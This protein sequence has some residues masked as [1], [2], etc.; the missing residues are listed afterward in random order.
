MRSS[1]PTPLKPFR[2]L[3]PVHAPLSPQT[4]TTAEI[5]LMT[6]PLAPETTTFLFT[7]I[8][9]STAQWETSPDM[10]SRLQRHLSILEDTV[11]AFG[12]MVFAW[13]GDGIAAAFSSADSAVH[14]AIAAQGALPE[15]GLRAR[16]G[17]HT[18]EAERVGDDHRGRPV[19]R[20]ARI[21]S[22]GH[23]GQILLSDLSAALIR[24]GPDPVELA[25]LG[26]HR[27]RGL[28]EPERLWQVLHPAL[29]TRFAPVQGAGTTSPDLPVPRT[30]LIGRE[31]ETARLAGLVDTTRIV[32]LTGTGGVGKTRLALHAAEQLSSVADARFVELANLPVGARPDEVART[33]AAAVG[34]GLI[35]DPIA[36]T[37]AMLDGHDAL[38]VI[39]NCEHVIEGAAEVISELTDRCPQLRVIATSREPLGIDGEHVIHVAPLAPSTAWTLFRSRAEA[40]G[41]EPDAIDDE[42][43]LDIVQRL[44]RLPLAIELTAARAATLGLPAIV[45]SLR[46]RSPSSARRRRGKVDRQATM[47]ATIAWSYDLLGPEEQRLLGQLAVFPSGAELDAVLDVAC[48][49]GIAAPE[50][51]DVLASLVD[52]SMLTIEPHGKG[53]RYRMLETMRAFVLDRLDAAGER[54]KAQLA[55]AEWVASI[56]DVP[57]AEASALTTE[58]A[59]IRLERE[60]CNWQEAMRAAATSGRADLAARLCGPPTA[61]FL[62]GRHDLVD[63]VR[64]V[65][66]LC[67]A[68][69]A[70]RRATLCALMVA[71]AGATD[72]AQLQVW[73]DEMIV[74]DDRDRTGLGSLMQWLARI[75]NG[76]FE[77]AVAVCLAGAEDPRHE[78]TTRDL[79]LSMAVLDHF[80][81]TGATTDP[82]GLIERAI[83]SA[84]RS[85][86]AL[87]RVSGRLGA[88][89]GLAATAPDRCIDLVRQAMADLDDVPALTRLT[90]PGSAFRLLGSLDPQVAAAG[91]LE[92]LDAS[93]CRESFVDLIPLSYAGALLEGVGHPAAERV[94]EAVSVTPAAPHL[95]MMDFVE[96]AR[97]MAVRST[98]DDLED[99]EAHVRDALHEIAQVE[100][101]AIASAD[102]RDRGDG[103]VR[104]TGALDPVAAADTR[105][106]ILVGPV[107]TP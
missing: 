40:A 42:L 80:S 75:W 50:A 30:P 68:D 24:S 64:S 35:D 7:D 32:T 12:G 57:F 20:A 5:E 19:N 44:D 28:T 59:A 27:L 16:M 22:L 78:Q 9:S 101:T 34:I 102:V 21:M 4:G 52:K 45:E 66:N 61:F 31:R 15:S 11:A 55:M 60:A 56:T 49:V 6:P 23:G 1:H 13:M 107:S 84:E 3:I 88:A 17:L 62:L 94:L 48:G 41:M 106:R 92:Q 39:D 103:G 37:A 72:P 8:E 83:A 91:L 82:D 96:H 25:D 46:H 54:V 81:L 2:E 99:L 53:V 14:A 63:C 18:G 33:V 105:M 85:D 38:L 69:A 43:A 98:A 89:W 36:S 67:R 76:D 77:G 104:P 86:V 26:T 95:S 10:P 70:Y 87:T 74:L 29:E 100:A 47:G 51:T 58:R 97:R 71:D 65:V 79:L 73:A 93:P 90:L